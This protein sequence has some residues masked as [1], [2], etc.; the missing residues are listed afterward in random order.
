VNLTRLRMLSE[1]AAR[2]SFRAAA[3]ALDYTPSAVSQQ[4]A[5]L[6]RE[7]GVRLVRRGPRGA[8]L[9][10]A[11]A[12]LVRHADVALGELVKARHALAALAGNGHPR[13]RVAAFPTATATVV[14]LAARSFAAG[15]PEWTVQVVDAQ[16]AQARELLTAGEVDAAVVYE[17]EP[18]GPGSLIGEDPMLLCLPAGHRL[19]ARSE[20]EVADL[21]AEQWV[22]GDGCPSVPALVELCLA[23]GF[24]P[25]FSPLQTHDYNAMQGLVATHGL[26]G[27]I[28][29]LALSARRPDVAIRRL[30]P[31][32][33]ARTLRYAVSDASHPA[34][35]RF[36][37]EV[38]SALDAALS[39][40]ARS[41]LRVLT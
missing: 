26:V 9:T 4:I 1:V 21:A 40:G 38:R 22:G 29:T 8:A 31:E 6:E 25:E 36:F 14:A 39:G 16:P 15:H 5:L 10:D 32:P 19:A 33:R 24:T 30:R 3:N 20:I 18:G 34:A 7:A 35:E 37:G 41:S 27:L 13:L 11:G 12:L 23:A 17:F 2:G 28:P